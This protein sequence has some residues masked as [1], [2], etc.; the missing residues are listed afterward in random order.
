MLALAS[1]GA[2]T[3]TARAAPIRAFDSTSVDSGS[4]WTTS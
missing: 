2:S 1:S 3:T 4:P